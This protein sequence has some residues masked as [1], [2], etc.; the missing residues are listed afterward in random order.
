MTGSD[1]EFSAH[2]H[3]NRVDVVHLFIQLCGKSQYEYTSGEHEPM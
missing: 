1:D 3:S 2:Q